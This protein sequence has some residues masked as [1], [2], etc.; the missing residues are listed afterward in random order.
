MEPELNDVGVQESFHE[1]G[2]V[3]HQFMGVPMA[4]SGFNNPN[5][6]AEQLAVARD[7]D[8][9][10][11]KRRDVIVQQLAPPQPEPAT[12]Y[13]QPAQAQPAPK[14]KTSSLMIPN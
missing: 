2:H 14:P 8:E 10:S 11:Y 5:P 6:L 7:I 13:V 12:V 4:E 3:V 1:L 9:I